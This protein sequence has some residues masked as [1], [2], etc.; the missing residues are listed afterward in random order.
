MSGVPFEDIQDLVK[1][2]GEFNVED[3]ESYEI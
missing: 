1:N 2:G 3:I